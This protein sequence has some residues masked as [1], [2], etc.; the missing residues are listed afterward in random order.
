MNKEASEEVCAEVRR[1]VDERVD[2]IRRLP[3]LNMSTEEKVYWIDRFN[4]AGQVVVTFASVTT[5]LMKEKDGEELFTMLREASMK[6]K[7]KVT[8]SAL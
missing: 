7:R 6:A 2:R 5:N 1:F 3:D 8:G 4:F